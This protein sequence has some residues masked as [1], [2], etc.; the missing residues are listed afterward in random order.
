MKN[1]INVK[2]MT[3]E[4]V[5]IDSKFKAIDNLNLEVKQC[6]FVAIIGHNG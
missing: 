3:F 1:I 2:D 6:D 4:Y 5:T